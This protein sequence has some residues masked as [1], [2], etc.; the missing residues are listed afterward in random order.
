MARSLPWHSH[1]RTA[2]ARTPR[3]LLLQSRGLKLNPITTLY[4]VSPCCFVFLL[5]PFFGLELLKVVNDDDVLVN[6]FYMITN[7]AVAFCLNMAVF[8]LIGKTSALSMNVAGVIKD[9]A[10][11]GISFF[12]FGDP[13]SSVNLGGYLVAFLAV[14]Y[15]NY[16]KYRS[17]N[18]EVQEEMARQDELVPMLSV[19]SGSEKD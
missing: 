6:P 8:L 3:R 15:Y 7:A 18:R 19:V 2:L 10:L 4:Y 14:C 13:V 11:I 1:T 5:V 16:D 12:V 17:K 9:W